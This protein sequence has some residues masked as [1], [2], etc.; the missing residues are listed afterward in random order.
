MVVRSGLSLCW[1]AGSSEEPGAKK[2]LDL[3]GA[4]Q[5]WKGCSV[6]S[7]AKKDPFGE[8]RGKESLAQGLLLFVPHLKFLL[9]YS[10]HICV[11]WK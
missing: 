5:V 10:L 2:A 3:E 4:S 8:T 1:R 7:K 6:C 9:S 11:S